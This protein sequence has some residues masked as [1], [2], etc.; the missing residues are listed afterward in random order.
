MSKPQPKKKRCPSLDLSNAD[1]LRGMDED[2]LLGIITR[3]YQQNKEL[4]ELLQILVREKHLSKNERFVNPD[5][6]SLFVEEDSSSKAPETKDS[7][8]SAPGDQSSATKT[9]SKK[10]GNTRNPMPAHLDR[11]TITGSR[12]SD[13]ELLCQCCSQLKVEVNQVLRNSRYEYKPASVFVEQFVDIV[14]ACPACGD[15]LVVEPEL[16]QTIENGTAGPALQAEIVVAKYEDHMPLHRQEQR[17]ARMGVPIARS[18]MVGW[19]KSTADRLLPLYDRMHEL[20]LLSKVIATDDTPVKVQVRKKSKNIKI[21]RIWIY[22]GD[23]DHPFNLFDYTEGR[24]RAGPMTFLAGFR[25]YLQG[26]CFSGNLALCAETGAIFVACL[27]HGRR[28]FIKALPNNKSACEEILQMFTDLFEIERSAR[29]LEI[30]ADEVKLMR[31]QESRPI[32]DK[33]K[34]WLEEQS[35]TALPRS[36]FGKGVNYCL[37]NWTELTNYL[38]DGNVRADNNLA[39]QEMKRVACGRKNWYFLGSEDS[40]KTAAVLLSITSTCKRNGVN[41]SEYIKDVLQRLTE[42]PDAELDPLLPNNWKKTFGGSEIE[43]CHITPEVAFA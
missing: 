31:E 36:A 32:L 19:M 3:L 8:K 38:L 2:T 14:Y 40:G 18:T 23:D 16:K 33:M 41:P 25:C 10:P 30:S 15:T 37:N 43:G 22:R 6:L 1:A 21:G 26:D 5:Q 28:Y 34:K 12:P 24:S 42:D 35:I 27:V 7:A 29:E 9:K 13:A 20:L 11:K 4:S 17:F 39:E